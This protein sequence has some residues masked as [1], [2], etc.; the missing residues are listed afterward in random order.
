MFRVLSIA[1]LFAVVACSDEPSDEQI[2]LISDVSGKAAEV[3]IEESEKIKDLESRI[4]DLEDRTEELE[5][6]DGG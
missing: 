5:N 1:L 4:D 6:R 3:A 2:D